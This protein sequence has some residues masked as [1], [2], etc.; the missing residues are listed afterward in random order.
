MLELVKTALRIKTDA[1]DTELEMLINAAFL[2][3]ETAG[4][5]LFT[6]A[7]ASDLVKTAVCTY[8]KA[9]FGDPDNADRIL[10]SYEMQKAQLSMR[11]GYTDFGEDGGCNV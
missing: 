11:S 4:V 10:K 6:A 3:L 8:C 9:N 1:F 2:D 7:N 5:N